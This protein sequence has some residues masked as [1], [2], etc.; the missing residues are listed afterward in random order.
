M[1]FPRQEYWSGLPFPSLG[2]HL[3]PEIESVSPHASP[4][5]QGAPGKP[6]LSPLGQHILTCFSA[7]FLLLFLESAYQSQASALKTSLHAKKLT[8]HF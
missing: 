5:R 3:D 4:A 8:K 2:D 1:E 6:L 7:P